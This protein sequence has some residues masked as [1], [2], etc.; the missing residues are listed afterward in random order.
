MRSRKETD[1]STCGTAN[2]TMSALMQRLG[3]VWNSRF[4]TLNE[5][6]VKRARCS[7]CTREHESNRS[8][9]I[10]MRDRH[11]H[12][13]GSA[14]AQSHIEAKVFDAGAVTEGTEQ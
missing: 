14:L 2:A 3:L 5:Y 11:C 4:L 9:R 6:Y 10:A 8:A 12:P 7:N 13:M 1:L